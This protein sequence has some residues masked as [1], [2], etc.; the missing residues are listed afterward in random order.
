MIGVQT[1]TSSGTATPIS[2]EKVYT[3]ATSQHL[4][5]YPSV[6][7]GLSATGPLNLGERYSI[8]LGCSASSTLG[9]PPT[10]FKRQLYPTFTT[11]NIRLKYSLKWRISLECAGEAEEVSGVAPVTILTPSE[12]QE[13]EKKRVLGTEG[14]KKNYDDLEA[15]VGMGVQFIGQVLQAVVG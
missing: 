11:Y 15:G 14:M 2:G 7:T 1:I 3:N 9:H 5:L 6:A 12:E 4:S 10:A 8:F 13:A